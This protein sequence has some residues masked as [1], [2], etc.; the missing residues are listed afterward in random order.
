M[1]LDLSE[2]HLVIEQMLEFKIHGFEAHE[3]I[4]YLGENSEKYPD[5]AVLILHQIILSDQ[6]LYFL[7]EGKE[8][9]ERILTFAL[10]A[11]DASKAKAIEIINVFGE[12]GDYSWRPLL[13]KLKG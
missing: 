9:L 6:E 3:I 10:G 5:L 1:P 2:L 11:D 4:K 7:A 12:R 8:A 13:D